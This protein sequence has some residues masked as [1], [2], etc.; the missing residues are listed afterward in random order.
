MK[1]AS[2]VL[3]VLLA[4]LSLVA[5]RHARRAWRDPDWEPD[6]L[7]QS[8]R[9]AVALAVLTV[10]FGVIFAGGSVFADVPGAGGKD[11]GAGLVAAGLLGVMFAGVCMGTTRRF[12]RP[13]FLIPPP[14]RPAYGQALSSGPAGPT[15]AGIQS[16]REARAFEA[17]RAAAAGAF[18]GAADV[19]GSA[20][21][22][23]FIVIAGQ[24]S[25]LAAGVDDTGR[26]VLTT[27]QL[28]LSTRRPNLSGQSRSWPVAD[29]RAIAAGPGADGMTLRCADGHEE[30]FAV[31]RRRGLWLDRVSKLLS[32]PGAGH[33][34]VWRPRRYGPACRRARRGGRGGALAG[35]GGAA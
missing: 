34:L 5:V 17:A 10:S 27:R 4:A 7:T 21:D 29:L 11:A 19:A 8:P 14:M 2:P 35:R 12:G 25:H 30:V 1:I 24:G 9:S 28:F 32:L 23:E 6:S 3:A 31:D 22:G 13:R 26:L 15:I 33:Q 20:A 18:D 16:A